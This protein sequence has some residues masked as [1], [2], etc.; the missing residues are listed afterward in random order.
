MARRKR[1]SEQFFLVLNVLPLK[2]SESLEYKA[3]IETDFLRLRVYIPLPGTLAQC[4]RVEKKWGFAKFPCSISSYP[5][6]HL[7]SGMHT[8]L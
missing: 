3:R 2:K 8:R 4:S 5:P 7:C 6:S 1:P